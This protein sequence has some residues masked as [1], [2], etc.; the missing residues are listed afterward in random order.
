MR[1]GFFDPLFRLAKNETFIWCTN[2]VG[3]LAIA[4]TLILPRVVTLYTAE[5]AARAHAAA[6]GWRAVT[7]L[8]CEGAGH[9]GF[10]GCRLFGIAADG[11]NAEIALRCDDTPAFRLDAD[12]CKSAPQ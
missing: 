12:R 9:D 5:D 1:N 6:L 3:I 8:R 2:V 7:W 11:T 10:V 4:A